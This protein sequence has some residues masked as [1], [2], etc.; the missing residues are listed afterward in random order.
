MRFSMKLFFFTSMLLLGIA[1]AA[2]AGMAEEWFAI[3]DQ[4]QGYPVYFLVGGAFGVVGFLLVMA[5]VPR[6]GTALEKPG[7]QILDPEGRKDQDTGLLNRKAFERDLV[8]LKPS[9]Y[10]VIMMDV[11]DFK[12]YQ[13]EHGNQVAQS[14]LQKIGKAARVHIRSNDRVYKYDGDLFAVLLVNC[15]KD[16]AIKIAEKIR[17][18][19]SQLDHSPFPGVTVSA[20]VVTFPQDGDQVADLLKVTEELLLSAKKSGKNSTFALARG[21]IS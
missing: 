20:A 6:E 5:L 8:T 16:Q 19:V 2:A 17:I 7:E 18:R 4:L 13:G 21:K 3:P 15:D 14:V 12:A 11:D 9:L 1:C 10:S